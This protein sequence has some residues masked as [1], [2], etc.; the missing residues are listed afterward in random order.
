M[1]ERGMGGGVYFYIRH[2]SGKTRS[3]LA[4]ARC[5]GGIT[6]AARRFTSARC[7]THEITLSG[8]N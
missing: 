1:G 5:I 2:G 8:A 3:K 6:G 7:F 4:A